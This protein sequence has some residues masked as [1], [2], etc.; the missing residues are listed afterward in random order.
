M[1]M[2]Q[3]FEEKP[4]TSLGSDKD[5]VFIELNRGRSVRLFSNPHHKAQVR[6]ASERPPALELVSL[7]VYNVFVSYVSSHAERPVLAA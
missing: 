3:I 5:M 2:L 4:L 6:S 7:C 1:Q